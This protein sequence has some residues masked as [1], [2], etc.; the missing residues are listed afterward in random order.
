MK[1]MADNPSIQTLISL[2][3][4]RNVPRHI[5]IIMDGNGRWAK[6]RGFV[7]SIGHRYGVEKLKELLTVSKAV[8][9]KYITVYAFSTE[10]WS[11]PKDEVDTLMHLIVEFINREIDNIKK[12]GARIHVLGDYSVLPEESKRAV[13]YAI[14]YTAENT[15]L[16]LN[17]A[18]NYGGRAEIVRAFKLMTEE[19]NSG[20]LK[21]DDIDE[22]TISEHLYTAGMPDPDL[23]IRTAGEMRLINFLPYQSAYSELWVSP[24]DLYWP[25]FNKEWFLRAIMDYQ[26]RERRFG[27]LDNKNI[28]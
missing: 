18:L 27:G 25:D 14:D 12:E 16:H 13:Q 2:V 1:H 4:S 21:I 24:S 8:G 6:M 20:K 3:K 19:I 28:K 17:V 22:K 11:R 15:E 26:K 9:V 7:R 5:A 10:N 23:V